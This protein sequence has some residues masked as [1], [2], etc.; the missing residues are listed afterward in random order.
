MPHFVLRTHNMPDARKQVRAE[1][2]TPDPGF[3]LVMGLRVGMDLQLSSGPLTVAQMN[4]KVLSTTYC[5]PV[6]FP[7]KRKKMELDTHVLHLVNR[8]VLPRLGGLWHWMGQ[9]L[10]LPAKHLPQCSHVEAAVVNHASPC[11]V[12]HGIVDTPGFVLFLW[13]FHNCSQDRYRKHKHVI[14]I[15]IW[16]PEAI[17]PSEHVSPESTSLS[18]LLMSHWYKSCLPSDSFASQGFQGCPW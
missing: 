6:C 4:F 7:W 12:T 2:G 13:L 8:A 16:E 18:L 14:L 10:H 17:I 1:I 3:G 5:Q 11:H 15:G 9:C